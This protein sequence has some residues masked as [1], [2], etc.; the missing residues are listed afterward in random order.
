MIYTAIVKDGGVFIPNIES[1]LK[2]NINAKNI[3]EGQK[4][5]LHILQVT[6]CEEN[7]SSQDNISSTEQNSPND[8][9]KYSLEQGAG[10]FKRYGI[11][12]DIEDIEYQQ[13]NRQQAVV[14]MAGLLKDHAN[15][16]LMD[17]EET[18]IDITFSQ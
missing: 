3:E 6:E 8:K 12:V 16:E 5:N 2:D 4:I 9:T 17:L 10:L 15:P 14:E 13:E 11:E 18:A 1:L 7:V